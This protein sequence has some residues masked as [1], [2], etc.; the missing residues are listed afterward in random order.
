MRRHDDRP[1]RP[2]PR[3]A[4]LPAAASR[5]IARGLLLMALAV[6]AGLAYVHREGAAQGAAADIGLDSPTTFPADI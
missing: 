6:L 3:S 2:R 5:R 1:S 4:V